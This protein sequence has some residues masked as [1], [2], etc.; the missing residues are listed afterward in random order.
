MGRFAYELAAAAQRAPCTPVSFILS[1]SN[2]MLARFQD[3]SVPF[4]CVPTVNRPTALSVGARFLPARHRLLQL[5]RVLRPTAVVSLMPHVWSPL[6]V[7]PIRAF[8]IRYLS[9]IHDGYAHP[10]DPTAILTRWLLEEARAADHVITLSRTVAGQV[11]QRIGLPPASILPLFHPDLTY[12]VSPSCRR[13]NAAEPLRLLFFG[14]IMRYKG[15]GLL[16]DA[17]ERLRGEGLYV[18]IGIAGHGEL[19]EN[20]ARLQRLG[21]EVINRWIDDDEL[22]SILA[23]YDAMACSHIEASQSGVASLAFGEGLPVVATPV[24]GLVEQVI[25]GRTGVLARDS[26]VE[27]YAAAIARLASDQELYNRIA[28]HIIDTL[29]ERSMSRFLASILVACGNVTPRAPSKADA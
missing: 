24:G 12:G 13:R 22:G 14:R 23:R 3:V 15:L 16:I 4:Y 8:G 9:T 11:Q 18:H 17:V 20:A 1:S 21:A 6:L 29:D 10:G 26:S 7:R 28:A 2:P 25:D 19:G 27:A 5:L